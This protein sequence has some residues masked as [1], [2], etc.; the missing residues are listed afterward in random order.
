MNPNTYAAFADELEKIAEEKPSRLRTFKP[1]GLG[2]YYGTS[3]LGGATL[4]GL[5]GGKKGALV[6]ALAAPGGAYLARR[7]ALKKRDEKKL[8]KTSAPS[9]ETAR[10]ANDLFGLP[11]SVPPKKGVRVY[12]QGSAAAASPDRSQ[13]PVDGQ[14]T[15]NIAAGNTMSPATGPGGV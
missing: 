2:F 6:G 15:A 8:E 12:E 5:I 10:R 9:S 11:L 13:T 14:S 4:G 1:G 3:A 7:H